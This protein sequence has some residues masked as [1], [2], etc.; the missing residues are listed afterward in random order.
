VEP[1]RIEL[2]VSTQVNRKLGQGMQKLGRVTEPAREKSLPVGEIGRKGQGVEK[3]PSKD[4][5]VS[6][7]RRVNIRSITDILETS[8]QQRNRHRRAANL[9]KSRMLSVFLPEYLNGKR[10]TAK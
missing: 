7:D 8:K 10:R 2:R 4:K 6:S 3:K 9:E 1:K 5:G